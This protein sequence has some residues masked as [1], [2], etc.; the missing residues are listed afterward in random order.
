[1]L[2]TNKFS[3]LATVWGCEHEEWHTLRWWNPYTNFKYRD[4]GLMINIVYPYI[5]ASPDGVVQHNCCGCGVLR[6][7]CLYCIRE[8]SP[9]DAAIWSGITTFC[10]YHFATNS[11]RRHILKNF[12]AFYIMHSSING[13]FDKMRS[14]DKSGNSLWKVATTKSAYSAAL[15]LSCV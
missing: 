1:M 15:T 2:S 5:G 6:I 13:S 12:S 8:S 3:T 14:Q 10:E 9:T 11:G 7:K 4:S